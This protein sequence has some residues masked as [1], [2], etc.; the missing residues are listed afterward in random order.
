M[1]CNYLDFDENGAILGIRSKIASV[2]A[3]EF[4][5]VASAIVLNAVSTLDVQVNTPA[6]HAK[7]EE[8]S[9]TQRTL[10]AKFWDL[11]NEP[12]HGKSS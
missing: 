2:A 3:I 4:V 1:V 5:L 10:Y 8:L 9:E 7:A 12:L 6:V 11:K